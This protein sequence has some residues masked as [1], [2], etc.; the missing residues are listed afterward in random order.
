MTE[1]SIEIEMPEEA[2]DP[3]ASDIEEIVKR[4]LEQLLGSAPTMVIVSR[5]D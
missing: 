3:D 2:A 4:G 1:F 5:E